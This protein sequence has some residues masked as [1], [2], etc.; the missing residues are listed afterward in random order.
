MI[1]YCV[2]PWRQPLLFKSQCVRVSIENL[3]CDF[4]KREKK[5]DCLTCV[6]FSLAIFSCCYYYWDYCECMSDWLTDWLTVSVLIILDFI[7]NNFIR[8]AFLCVHNEFYHWAKKPR[9]SYVWQAIKKGRGK[10]NPLPILKSLLFWTNNKAAKSLHKI[11]CSHCLKAF[12]SS[13]YSF[14]FDLIACDQCAFCEFGLCIFG[15]YFS[16]MWL[17]FLIPLF[18]ACVWKMYKFSFFLFTKY[19]S[20]VILKIEKNH[21][22]TEK[23]QHT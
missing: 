8:L 13:N 20:F 19:G 4:E 2:T 23:F 9:A 17:P 21:S 16:F 12:Q 3:C 11:R 5:S 7:W 15:K 18:A 14:Q 10:L 6:G 1:F 22:N